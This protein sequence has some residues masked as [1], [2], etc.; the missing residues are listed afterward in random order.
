MMQSWKVGL[1]A[2]GAL[3]VFAAPQAAMAASSKATASVSSLKVLEAQSGSRTETKWTPINVAT[4]RTANQKDLVFDAA[5]QCGLLTDT[6][7]SSKGGNKNVANA[8]ASI[9]VRIRIDVSDGTTRYAMPSSDLD[10]TSILAPVDDADPPGITYCE[11]LQQLEAQFGGWD[12]TADLDTGA[13]TCEEEESVRLLLRTLTAASFNFVLPDLVSGVHT[14]TVEAKAIADTNL[15][16]GDGFELGDSSAE[17][18]VGLGSLDVDEVRFV[19][20]A[21]IEM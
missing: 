18:F 3:A 4:I 10:G 12:C 14:V 16:D 11:R 21:D 6:T 20:D 5:L 15:F 9:R 13:V 7:V 8:V 17:A 2:L 1:A 19:K